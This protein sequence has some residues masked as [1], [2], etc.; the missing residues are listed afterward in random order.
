ME[1][2]IENICNLG[3]ILQEHF[4][5]HYVVVS[6]DHEDAYSIG[7]QYFH[8]VDIVQDVLIFSFGIRW[9]SL[10]TEDFLTLRFVHIKVTIVSSLYDGK[11]PA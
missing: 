10:G 5:M 9:T 2:V 1:D 6:V 11:A 7:Y 3:C 4:S 8:P